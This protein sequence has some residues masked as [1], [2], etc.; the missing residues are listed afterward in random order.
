M[1]PRN[2]DEEQA[3]EESVKMFL[4]TRNTSHLT[5]L[6]NAAQL[7][8]EIGGVRGVDGDNFDFRGPF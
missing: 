5:W 4:L 6:T 2:E 7:N 1:S 3:F 8:G